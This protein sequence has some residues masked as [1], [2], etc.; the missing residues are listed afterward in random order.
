MT[1][2]RLCLAPHRRYRSVEL[3]CAARRSFWRSEHFDT[4]VVDEE[5]RSLGRGQASSSSCGHLRDRSLGHGVSHWSMHGLGLLHATN[6]DRLCFNHVVPGIGA[7]FGVSSYP[8]AFFHPQIKTW[9]GF[10][11]SL[12]VTPPSTQ[13]APP[14]SVNCTHDCPC[15]A[16][17]LTACPSLPCQPTSTC[18]NVVA[19]CYAELCPTDLQ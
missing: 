4:R 16:F 9:R 10:F 11:G 6:L 18:L 3:V 12:S 14:G 13:N 2:L 8:I 15:M 5:Q 1:C 19:N 17:I 7:Q